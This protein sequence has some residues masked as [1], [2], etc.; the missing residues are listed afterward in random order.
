[1]AGP[2]ADGTVSAICAQTKHI[3]C[4]CVDITRDHL[5]KWTHVP[6][7]KS[8]TLDIIIL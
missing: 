6:F 5:Q 1:M 2:L 7:I 4:Y 8:K 3:M